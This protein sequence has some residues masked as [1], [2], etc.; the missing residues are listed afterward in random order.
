M[1]I[2]K[3]SLCLLLLESRIS[4][5]PSELLLVSRKSGYFLD[6]SPPSSWLSYHWNL[7]LYAKWGRN[8]KL[9][10]RWL[11]WK[12]IQLDAPSDMSFREI[13]NQEFRC[14]RDVA[15]LEEKMATEWLS[16]KTCFLCDRWFFCL[17][18]LK[19]SLMKVKLYL[20]YSQIL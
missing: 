14:K 8:V 9:L 17:C 4:P 19:N 11:F 18:Q 2:K 3:E 1:L 6:E 16:V 12:Y 10:P 7:Q 20:A 15:G 13:W 5:T